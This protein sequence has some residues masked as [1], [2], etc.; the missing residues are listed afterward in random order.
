LINIR[1]EAELD[2]IRTAC[3]LTAETM[4][5]ASRLIEPGITTYEI[6]EEA[7]RYIES[8]GGEAA[9]LGYNGFPGAICVSVN[10]EVVHG[11]PSDNRKLKPGDIVKLDIGTYI[12]GF[13]GDMAR[14]YPVGDISESALRLM[15]TTEES[16]YEGIGSAVAGNHVGDIGASVQQ[17][18]EKRGFSVVRALVGHGIGRNLHEDPQVPNFGR[19]NDGALLRTGMVICIE[20]MVNAGTWNVRTL[21]DE[22]TVVTADGELSAHYENTCIIRDGYPEILTLMDEEKE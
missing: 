5:V 17:Y 10:D 19:R 15:K 4:G 14:T 21:D 1:S 3:A 20:P 12:G 2:K 6:S 22:W 7:R 11:I 16:L 8:H 13:Y 18:V 9:F